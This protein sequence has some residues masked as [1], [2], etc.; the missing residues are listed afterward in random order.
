MG[1]NSMAGHWYY[2]YLS[3][4]NGV[5][6]VRGRGVPRAGAAASNSLANPNLSKVI[7][8]NG[9]FRE[10]KICELVVHRIQLINYFCK[11]HCI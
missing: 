2:I 1:H 8:Q 5:C 10:N 7:V 3:K 4:K 11:Y 9:K 6:V